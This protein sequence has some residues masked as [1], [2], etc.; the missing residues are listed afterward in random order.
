[1]KR[2]AVM[3]W[4]CIATMLTAGTCLAGAASGV[5]VTHDIVY[6]T[7]R[8]RALR[9]DLYRQPG[10]RSVPVMV[11]VHGGGWTHG[12][13]PTSDAPFRAALAMGFSVVAVEYR[14]A[15]EARAPA[16]VQDVRCALGWVHAHAGRYRFDPHR[17]VVQGVSAG[18]HL[19]LL[20]AMAPVNAGL[21][22]AS[23]DTVPP[24]AAVLD[25][26]GIADV[27]GWHTAS[28]AMET[29]V[30]EGP[31]F[32]ERAKRVSPMTYV[33]RG[34]PPVFIAHGDADPT[35]PYAQSQ[36]LY[37]ALRRAGVPTA[38]FRVPGGKHGNF[39]PE[40]TAAVWTAARDFLLEN[41]VLDT[42]GK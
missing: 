29:W 30:G 28:R 9:L 33:G 15:G 3:A 40:Q 21:D 19:A 36:R 24:V 12:S 27:P 23:C 7:V 38:F 1:M 4:L 26:Y 35:V 20:A 31:H 34:N 18:G 41:H 17:M 11:H 22:D 10:G 37:D 13:R 25:F 6:A 14:L 8:G 16:A 39:N 32:A 42:A 2:A 5:T